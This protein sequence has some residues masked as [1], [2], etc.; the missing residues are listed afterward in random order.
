MSSTTD[1]TPISPTFNSPTNQQRRD[2]LEKHLQTRPELQ[3]LKDRHILLNTSVAPGL[4]AAQAELARQQATNSLRK[5][6]ENRP[7]R[8][9][10]VDRN[11]LPGRP[12]V[13][14]ALQAHAKEL[15]KHMLADNLEH[16]IKERP[17]PDELIEKGIL[18]LNEDPRSPAE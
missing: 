17:D 14:P 8:D 16:K 12:D 9:E 4:Q 5:H 13:A 15:E 1:N 11:I 3:D 2:S 10:L 7:E 18:D 6:L